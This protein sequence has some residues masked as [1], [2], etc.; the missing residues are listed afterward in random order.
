MVSLVHL[1]QTCRSIPCSSYKNNP[2][3][4]PLYLTILHNNCLNY[5]IS[6][7]AKVRVWGQTQPSLGERSTRW[8]GQK[9][10]GWGEATRHPLVWLLRAAGTPQ[11][12]PVA[13]ELSGAAATAR[14]RA[15][16]LPDRENQERAPQRAAGRTLRG[17]CPRFLILLLRCPPHWLSLNNGEQRIS[18]SKGAWSPSGPPP[19]V[20]GLSAPSPRPCLALPAWW[21]P[22]PA[23]VPVLLHEGVD[24][25]RAER[26]LQPSR[27]TNPHGR[28]TKT[29]ARQNPRT[30]GKRGFTYQ[31]SGPARR[32]HTDLGSPT[33]EISR[34]NHTAIVLTH[35]LR[36]PMKP[37]SRTARD[38]RRLPEAQ[39]SRTPPL[40]RGPSKASPSSP[41]AWSGRA[42]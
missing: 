29:E 35:V 20:A 24:P 41:P 37:G 3:F 33:T 5:L 26:P 30:H 11:A 23:R 16:S 22:G 10:T 34:R 14:K 4:S 21:Q 13:S 42:L 18:K 6:L 1:H 32:N 39:Q 15:E 19:A 27:P 25:A 31:P 28:N 17:L 36:W 8:W 2:F 7:T 40:A 12:R 38:S 9:D